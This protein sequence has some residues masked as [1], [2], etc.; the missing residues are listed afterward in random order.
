MRNCRLRS[1]LIEK[2]SRVTEPWS[3]MPIRD[4]AFRSR[5]RRRLLML[6]WTVSERIGNWILATFILHENLYDRAG[7]LETT[8]RF[9]YNGET[10]DRRFT[11]RTKRKM[12]KA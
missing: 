6:M 9:W 11:R 1:S 4:T 3:P 10:N 5:S 2:T 7:K 8:Y 12:K